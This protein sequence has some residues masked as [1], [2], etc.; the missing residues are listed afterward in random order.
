MAEDRSSTTPGDHGGDS[1]WRGLKALIFGNQ[2]DSLRTQ[3]EDAIDAHEDDP[4][5][6]AKGDLS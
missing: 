5:P 3:L 1:I 6:D 2:D 4:A